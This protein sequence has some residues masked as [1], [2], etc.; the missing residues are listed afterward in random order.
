MNR[1]CPI[2]H[3]E[4][5]SSTKLATTRWDVMACGGCGMTYLRNAP[6]QEE[7]E[8][9]YDWSKTRSSERS[10]RRKRRKFYYAMS[11]SLKKMKRMKRRG[12]RKEI[13][14]IERYAPRAGGKLLDIG[15]ADGGTLKQV[16]GEKWVPFGIEPSPSLVEKANAYCQPLGGMV[17]QD[18][19]VTGLPRLADER[20][21][22]IMMRSYL[23]H[24]AFAKDVLNGARAAMA[25]E[26]RLI[27]KVP[28]YA[29]WNSKLRGP[30]WPG[31][32]YPDHVNYFRPKDLQRIVSEAGFSNIYFPLH[33]RL[34]TSDNM[35]MIAA[36]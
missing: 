36:P 21:Q 6:S 9:A 1:N 26:G 18:V 24:E 5:A 27:I 23:E 30:G 4:T 16:D 35:W 34:P 31:V 20:F 32:R 25:P 8:A 13:V 19:G 14:F 22:C 2:C 28:N 33:F 7:L 17:L 3:E 12:R 29:C 15:C 11:D 10:E